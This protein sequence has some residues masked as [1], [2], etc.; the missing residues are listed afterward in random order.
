MKERGK[1]SEAHLLP[2]SEDIK[3]RENKF[4]FHTVVIDKIR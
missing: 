2:S 3:I 4:P 1:E